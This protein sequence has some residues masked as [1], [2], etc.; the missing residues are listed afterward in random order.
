LRTHRAR[1]L[2]A[3]QPPEERMLFR[4]GG[5][6]DQLGPMTLRF[7]A[8]R[9]ELLHT[10][11]SRTLQPG[12]IV[13]WQP[14][15]F[16]LP[17]R[18]GLLPET[19]IVPYPAP[20][21]PPLARS[22][23]GPWRIVE[24]L[25][26]RAQ[27]ECLRVVH[28]ETG[29]TGELR[30]SPHD[31][32][33]EGVRSDIALLA[34]LPRHGALPLLLDHGDTDGRPYYVLEPG[35]ISLAE[36]L[37]LGARLQPN[38]VLAIAIDIVSA[39]VLLHGRGVVHAAIDSGNIQWLVGAGARLHEVRHFNEG[40]PDPDPERDVVITRPL[41][42]LA[43]EEWR[44]LRSSPAAD[45]Y[46][47]GV[48]LHELLSG[49]RFFDGS[50]GE[51]GR[52][53]M[54]DTPPRLQ[55][56][57][58]PLADLVAQLLLK[59]PVQ[60]PPART[61]LERLEAM[62][63]PGSPPPLGGHEV[64]PGVFERDE[65]G[66]RVTDIR[67]ADRR[68][69]ARAHLDALRLDGMPFGAR[70]EELT[71]AGDWVTFRRPI[72]PPALRPG[73]LSPVVAQTVALAIAMPLLWL[74]E[75]GRPFT[76]FTLSKVHAHLDGAE[77]FRL[78][79]DPPDDAARFG[80][81]RDPRFIAP[82][83]HDGSAPISAELYRAGV[84]AH[85]LLVG[86][87]P[88]PGRSIRALRPE[89]PQSVILLVDRMVARDPSGRQDADELLAL[90]ETLEG[91]AP[92]ME[93]VRR[94]LGRPVRQPPGERF[95]DWFV[96]ELLDTTG[97]DRLHGVRHVTGTRGV[98]RVLELR[99][100]EILERRR[101]EARALRF[102]RDPTIV[103][104]IDEVEIDGAPVLIHEPLPPSLASRLAGGPLSEETAL[105]I[106]RGAAVG[107]TALHAEAIVH[108]DIKPENLRLDGPYVRLWD[109]SIARFP[110][111]PITRP[112]AVMGTLPYL[113]PEQC[114]GERVTT[115]ADVYALGCTL[116]EMLSGAPPF[117]AG[118]NVMEL[119][120]AH[121]QTPPPPLRG[122]RADVGALVARLLAKDP[123][124]RPTAAELVRL[125]DAAGVSAPVGLPPPPRPRTLVPGATVSLW[126]VAEP[127]AAGAEAELYRV[128]AG[129]RR[130]V[131]KLWHAPIDPASP[132]WRNL[133]LTL[134]E[135]S[136]LPGFPT[137]YEAGVERGR[138]FLVMEEIDG[139]TWGEL[140][141]VPVPRAACVELCAQLL[142]A[143]A[144]AHETIGVL[145]DVSPANVKLRTVADGLEPVL[146]DVVLPHADRATLSGYGTPGFRSPTVAAGG[147]PSVASDLYATGLLVVALL[148]DLPPPIRSLLEG[149]ATAREVAASMRRL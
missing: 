34:S 113:S 10:G 75:R 78:V 7:A 93:A 107:L 6:Q 22:Q 21:P 15:A 114:R 37:R 30:V 48:V 72:P 98:A 62:A 94:V 92:W 111:E 41:G 133:R 11:S 147:F 95:G 23:I 105:A 100:D 116:F 40:D 26:A 28:A 32:R 91:A 2:L 65:D 73:R 33:D 142:E 69:S 139:P 134:A 86:E 96:E 103:Q 138:P 12:D 131:L 148:P 80:D 130:A 135:C 36:R 123:A 104:V 50:F 108:R 83:E 106:T 99:S 79:L 124:A 117:A 77:S 70:V 45:I 97:M 43:P 85:L 9:V 4:E 14:A 53:H 90:A 54:M 52:R 76:G 25:E 38:E 16:F 31:W 140:C 66:R 58:E 29:V 49:S 143:V 61:L 71:F 60:R 112:G 122:V 59:E 110:G 127:L 55:D 146:L 1:V 81:V 109:F 125:L 74:R 137:F 141:R 145:G 3:A 64:R 46:G 129:E 57:P 136:N 132:R 82:E 8:D 68:P 84:V 17:G 24:E 126:T 101:R 128:R 118:D 42:S 87:E 89:L 47:L 120:V 18:E 5:A 44:G 56:V 144:L 149:G 63:L 119:L 39:L 35:G 51:I 67:A 13:C 20:P 121:M 27:T 115:Q 19:I 88:V 102:R